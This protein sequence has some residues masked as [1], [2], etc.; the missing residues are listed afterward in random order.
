MPEREKWIRERWN[1]KSGMRDRWN[2]TCQ[3]GGGGGE[4][5]GRGGT[6][7]SGEW[8]NYGTK[9][10]VERFSYNYLGGPSAPTGAWRLVS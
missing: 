2:D 8:V 9:T 3:G 10:M 5:L 4:Q 7:S 6:A 1:V